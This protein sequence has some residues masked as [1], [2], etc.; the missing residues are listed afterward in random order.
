MPSFSPTLTQLVP[1]VV[2]PIF[3]WS[4]SVP[5]SLV[6]QVAPLQ[7]IDV[8][9]GS[10]HTRLSAVLQLRRIEQGC[11]ILVA[12]PGRL[13]DLIERARVSLSRV[14]FLAL[15]EADRMLDMGFE[16]QVLLR[17]AAAIL[18]LLSHEA[19]FTMQVSR[20]QHLLKMATF[21]TD[22]LSRC[23]PL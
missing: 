13:S 6:S 16:P 18:E 5:V 3:A 8:P 11:D 19:R 15:D 22:Q 21:E 7:L 10:A 23:T 9:Q 1:P 14:M 17:S 20:A 2:K 4:V 12:T